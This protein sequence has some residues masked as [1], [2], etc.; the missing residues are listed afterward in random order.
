M[1]PKGRLA[2]LLVAAFCLCS[3][4]AAAADVIAVSGEAHLQELVKAHPFLAVELYAPWCGHC[5][6]LEPEWAKAA[7]QL[8]DHDPPIT[9]AKVDATE[10]ANEP[11]KALFKV[12]GFPTIKI[13]K[14]D[15]AKAAPYEGP[16]DEAGIVAYLKRQVQPAYSQ[17]ASAEEIAAAKAESEVLVLAYLDSNTSAEFKT[18]AEVA[19][20]LRNDIDFRFVTDRSLVDPGCAADCTSPLLTMHKREEPGEVATYDGKLTPELLSGWAAVKSLPLVLKFGSPSGMKHLQKAFSAPSPRLI[21]VVQEESGELLEQLQQA[22]RANAELA[23]ILAVAKDSQRLLDFYKVPARPGVTLLLED[24][25][26]AAKYLKADAKPSDV[27]EFLREFQE[28]A[29]ERWLKSEEPPADNSGPVRVLVAKTFEEEVFGGGKDVFVELYAPWCGHCKKLEPIWDSVG[30]ALAGDDGIV[31]AKMDATQNDIPTPK[32]T[33]KGYPTLVFVTAKGDVVPFGGKREKADLL[34]FIASTR[35]TKP[36]G[37]AE[38]EDDTE[39]DD[40]DE[41]GSKDEL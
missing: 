9:L 38:E 5:K 25:K 39:D 4:L 7:A 30:K 33:A 11:L 21:A 6:K 17:L 22:S 40:E 41:T 29:L 26:A 20:Q 2:A 27:P 14:G 16:R 34:S 37:D 24:P 36:S 31:V 35:V 8:K 1:A 28:G 19:D 32:I 10:K 18:F 23:V 12:S 3:T 13:I 15:T